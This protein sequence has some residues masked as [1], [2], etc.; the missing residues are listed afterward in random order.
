MKMYCEVKKAAGL[1]PPF[2]SS[3]NMKVFVPLENQLLE[4]FEGIFL[5]LLL[6]IITSL[7]SFSI[8]ELFQKHKR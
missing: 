8:Y 6:P 3:W 5:L 4:S 1:S 2:G 7:P